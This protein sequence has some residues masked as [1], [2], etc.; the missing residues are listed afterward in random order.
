VA[1]RWS[2]TFT[3]PSLQT[4]DDVLSL[5]L[6]G[7]DPARVE[8]LLR[9]RGDYRPH[10]QFGLDLNVRRPGRGRAAAAERRQS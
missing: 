4:L 7:E 10:A 6:R 8:A 5:A 9:K 3:V 1:C 2:A